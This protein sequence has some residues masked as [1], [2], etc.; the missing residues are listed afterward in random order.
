MMEEEK[1]NTRTARGSSARARH[2]GG[3]VLRPRAPNVSTL[4][5]RRRIG[6][7]G[8]VRT[9]PRRRGTWNRRGLEDIRAPQNP[10][11]DLAGAPEAGDKA[12]G[13]S[14]YL[15]GI[16]PNLAL[17]ASEHA[18][19]EPLLELEANH[20]ACAREKRRSAETARCS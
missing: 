10:S 15:I 5:R 6:A 1:K 16:T 13:E 12:R 3:A 8:T 2:R 14:T 11:L 20:A 17:P 4:D 7:I 18:S 9:S 19:S